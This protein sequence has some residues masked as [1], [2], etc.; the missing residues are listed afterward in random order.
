M[1]ARRLGLTAL[2][3]LVL[4]T[5]A[6]FFVG[7]VVWLIL[8]P[9]KSGY[10]LATERPFAVGS[11]GNVATAWHQLDAFNDRIFRR[12]FANSLLYAFGATALTL[13]TAIP[14]GYG[15]ATG[16]FAGRKLILT[17][18]II[19]MIMPATALVLP[20]FLELNALHMLGN[21][22]AVILPFAFF[23]FGVYLAY[24]YFAT[25]LPPGLLDAARLDGC[26]EWQVF[27]HVAAPLAKP[28]VAL[29]FFFSLATDWSS[30]FL[31]YVVLF[32][33]RQFPLQV[34]LADI[35]LGAPRPQLALATLIACIPI[36]GVFVLLQRAL[37]RGL[38]DGGM[39]S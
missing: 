7:P 19:A 29:I 30:F 12:W 16:R 38:F 3:T 18:T 35:L 10:Q 21:P 25:A 32:D 5:A 23:P 17:L 9:T 13:V 24:I 20:I 14:A 4:L 22:F 28:V 15:L 11:W 39:T 31:P 34:G 2:R 33:S 27:R 8:A 6:V 36:A 26:S 1:R 37:V